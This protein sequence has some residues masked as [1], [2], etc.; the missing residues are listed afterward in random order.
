MD[1]ITKTKKILTGA[2][3]GVC[4][5]FTVGVNADTPNPDSTNAKRVV[6]IQKWQTTNG[7]NVYFVELHQLPIVDAGVIFAAGSAYDGKHPGIANMVSR[8]LDEGTAKLTSDQIAESF[9]KVGSQYSAEAGRDF[10]Y[11]QFRSLSDDKY[12][13]PT[14]NVFSQVV[15]HAKFPQKEFNR[16]KQQILMSLKL[17]EQQP[18]QIA[19][20]AFYSS[21]YGKAPY[22]HPV[23][24]NIDSVRAINQPDLVN[25]YNRYFVSQNATIVMVGDLDKSRA[26]QIAERISSQIKKGDPAQ[27]FEKV[28]ATPRAVNKNISFPSTQTTVLMGQIGI[29][30]NSNYYFPALVGNYVLGGGVLTSRLMRVIREDHGYAY[31]VAS[32]FLTMR[33]R[34]PFMIQLQTRNHEAKSASDLALKTLRDFIHKGPTP[35]ELDL[36]K[37][38]IIQGFPLKLASNAA[39]F[40]NV[41][42]IAAYQLPLNYLDTY[43]ENVRQITQR[44][45][46]DTFKKL[47][48][49]KQ[50]VTIMVGNANSANNNH[51]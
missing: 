40:N 51:S 19:T 7:T 21:I 39:I 9:D 33:D 18:A 42:N 23:Q 38:N 2:V 5:L 17:Q 13:T 30:K 6:N 16:V 46:Q 31:H 11:V 32:A 4:L 24:G 35:S 20:K 15:S 37:R 50:L 8:M 26:N 25:F 12:L 34:G 22:G 3:A 48:N 45:I 41:S 28:T 29:E 47:I 27:S 49:T 10:T 14:L 1:T 36:A 43:R 44:D